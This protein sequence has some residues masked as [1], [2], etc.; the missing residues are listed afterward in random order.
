MCVCYKK[1]ENDQM[2]PWLKNSYCAVYS[3]KKRYIVPLRM[4]CVRIRKNCA[5]DGAVVSGR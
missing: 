5:E 4:Q 2:I 1:Y 3:A